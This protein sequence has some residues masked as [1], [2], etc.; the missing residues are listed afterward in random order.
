MRLFNWSESLQQYDFKVQYQL[1][2]EKVVADML[3]RSSDKESNDDPDPVP[4]NDS[5]F[6]D[7]I[8]VNSIFGSP[9][10][11][12]VSQQRLAESTDLHTTTA[13]N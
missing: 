2:G 1:G 4:F 10:L 3:N 12:T 6:T 13:S 5:E 11:A 9:A 7:T 8:E